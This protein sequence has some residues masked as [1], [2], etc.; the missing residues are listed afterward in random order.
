[1]GAVWD[2]HSHQG[3]DEE[4]QCLRGHT[5][6]PRSIDTPPLDSDSDIGHGGIQSIRR[7]CLRRTDEGRE[8]LAK[9]PASVSDGVHQW[10][11]MGR[12]SAGEVETVVIGANEIAKE[13]LVMFPLT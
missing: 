10:M 6:V 7:A 8:N 2:V 11:E 4:D 12:D 3:Q 9:M 5:E 13:T 1:M